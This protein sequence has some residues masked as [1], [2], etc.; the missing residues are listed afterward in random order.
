MIAKHFADF[1]HFPFHLK[2]QKTTV[3]LKE[4]TF[5]FCTN[6]Y[7]ADPEVTSCGV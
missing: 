2:L 1:K 4:F 6:C 7:T 5:N 3:F